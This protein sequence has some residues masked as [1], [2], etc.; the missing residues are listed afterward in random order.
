MSKPDPRTIRQMLNEVEA[1]TKMRFSFFTGSVSS[2]VEVFEIFRVYDGEKGGK[3][4]AS[5]SGSEKMQALVGYTDYHH[6]EDHGI[7]FAQLKQVFRNVILDKPREQWLEGTGLHADT[8]ARKP[9]TRGTLQAQFEA[10]P[11]GMTDREKLIRA[12]FGAY[13]DLTWVKEL[14]P[15]FR[16][17]NLDAATIN[18]YR[19]AWNR[20]TEARDW[21]WWVEHTKGTPDAKLR[22]EIAECKAEIEAIRKESP[23][24]KDG[25]RGTLRAQLEAKPTQSPGQ[26]KKPKRP[27]E[28]ERTP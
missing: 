10:K 8:P 17:H 25:I 27:K 20:H 2:P 3:P 23:V 19:E 7:S 12:H 22:E 18:G 11:T 24:S 6:Y 1:V 13:S 4:F 14:E 5:L 28:P 9:G 16:P 15:K 21:K 26:G